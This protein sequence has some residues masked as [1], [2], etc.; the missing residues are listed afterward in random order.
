MD[1]NLHPEYVIL[2]AFPLQQWLR[3]TLRFGFVLHALTVLFCLNFRHVLPNVTVEYIDLS[4]V[5]LA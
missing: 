5:M 3:K 2:I 1:T 4:K